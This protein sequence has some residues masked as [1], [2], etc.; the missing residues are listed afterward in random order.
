MN[1][2]RDSDDQLLVPHKN[3][4]CRKTSQL[5]AE[6]DKDYRPLERVEIDDMQLDLFVVDEKTNLPISR[7]WLTFRIC[8]FTK[9]IVGYYLSPLESNRGAEV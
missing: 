6:R 5:D 9:L 4:R 2:F 3:A 7:P 1:R 8:A